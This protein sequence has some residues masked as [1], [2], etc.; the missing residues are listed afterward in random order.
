M[1]GGGTKTQTTNTSQQSDP[2]APAQPALQQI[3]G[4]ASA[5]YNANPTA[6]VYTGQR[7]AGLGTDT[8]AGL[9]AMKDAASEGA[10]TA[11]SA[12]SWLNGL[13]QN[14]GTTSATQGATAGLA[15]INPT[16]DTSGVASAASRLSDPN[17]L[18]STTGSALA[19]GAY[20][21]DSSRLAGLANQFAGGTT[22]TQKSLQSVADGADLNGSPQLDALVQRSQNDASSQVA[23]KFAAS[24]RYGSGRFSGAVADAV[25][26]VGTSLRYQDLTNQQA[27]QAQAASAIDSANNARAG[28]ASSL[29]GQTAAINQGNAGLATTG[30]N[31]SLSADQAGLAGQGTLAAL[32]GS[33]TDRVIGQA[34]TLLSAAQGDRAAGL[35]GIASTPT[36]QSALQQPGQTL[37]QA[38]AIQ[39]AAKQDQI[40]A[41]M[42][43]F[44]DTANAPWQQL[45]NYAG[46]VQPIAGLGSSS[47]GTST[48]QIKEN[49]GL[50]NS[51]LGG[52]SGLVGGAANLGK[53]GAFGSSGWLTG[54]SGSLASLFALSD[55]RAKDNI[56]EIGKTHDGQPLYSFTYKGDSKPQIGLM[57]Q[58]V[59]QRDPSAVAMLPN[60]LLAVDYGRALSPSAGLAKAG[61]ASSFF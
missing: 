36:V 39:D 26:N 35:A 18:A 52:V 42:Q 59:M 48:Q 45:G 46:L 31:L 55:E 49:P 61:V 14:G 17:S 1:S 57:A 5:A 41:D 53:A 34:G 20:S 11:S 25:D 10:G 24:G 54:G 16:V 30:A 32:E 15:G 21:T 27:R 51:I 28:M 33:N 29:F 50:L 47:T 22:Q 40:N 60:G 9:G 12:N 13:L 19:G 37:A 56:T 38:G 4:G 3:L 58:E 43:E 2:W 23:Q 7:T 8:M 44:S 6:P